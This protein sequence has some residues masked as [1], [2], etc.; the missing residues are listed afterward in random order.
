MSRS[1]GLLLPA[2][3]VCSFCAFFGFR[4]L[5]LCARFFFPPTDAIPLSH[6]TLHIAS[7]N[8]ASHVAG[9]VQ[10]DTLIADFFITVV[11]DVVHVR[12]RAF[13]FPTP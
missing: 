4:F 7:F 6:A 12:S 2:R 11:N 9:H 1:V 10:G 8:L 5:F 3:T 13:R